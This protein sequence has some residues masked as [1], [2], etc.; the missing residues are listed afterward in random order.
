MSGRTVSCSTLVK[1]CAMSLPPAGEVSTLDK[2]KEAYAVYVI[3]E[4][5]GTC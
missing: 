3:C 1:G 5:H 2:I 4:L